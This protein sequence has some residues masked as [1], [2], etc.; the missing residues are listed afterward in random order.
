MLRQEGSN[1]DREMLSAFHEAGL[2]AWDV[3]MN[4]LLQ[5][6]SFSCW[7]CAVVLVLLGGC[8]GRSRVCLV[9]A[10]GPPPLVCDSMRW[11]CRVR[12]SKG[13]VTLT[14]S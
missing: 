9:V 10:W 12:I 14:D 3:N 11:T 8:L 6:A 7:L 4:D 1:G 13:L 5:G 2:E